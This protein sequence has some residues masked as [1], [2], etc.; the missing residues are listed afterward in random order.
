[1]S[2]GYSP[3][4]LRSPHRDSGLALVVFTTNGVGVP[5]LTADDGNIVSGVVRTGAGVYTITLNQQYK[6]VRG[7]PNIEDTDPTVQCNCTAGVEGL[8]AAN[9]VVVQIV[10]EA[11]IGPPQGVSVLYD[12]AAEVVD[13][14]IFLTQT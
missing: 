5:T 4:P 9:T 14:L 3:H 2:Q 11:P 6:R 7:F 8:A 12:P 10:Q 1:M 13:V